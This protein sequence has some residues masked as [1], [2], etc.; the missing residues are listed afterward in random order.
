MRAGGVFISYRRE[1]SQGAAGR[2]YGDLRRVLG[3]EFVFRDIDAIKP[4]ADFATEITDTIDRCDTLVALIGHKWIEAQDEDGNRRLDDPRDF[5]RTEIATALT[6]GKI[7]IPLLVDEARMPRENELPDPLRGLAHR[8]ALQIS[9]FR[10]DYD[11]GR[12]VS[13]IRRPRWFRNKVLLRI[14]TGILVAVV[15]LWVALFVFQ[16]FKPDTSSAIYNG[17]PDGIPLSTAGSESSPKSAAS[18]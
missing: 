8:N 17:A 10:W 6:A 1:D 12:L 9:D 7:V 18:P 13:L 5:V 16:A 11:L 2:L 4:G 3:K 15:L 14:V